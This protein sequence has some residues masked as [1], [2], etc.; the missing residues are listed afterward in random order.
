MLSAHTEGNSPPPVTYNPDEFWLRTLL[1]WY[2]GLVIRPSPTIREI[3]ERRAVCWLGLGTLAVVGSAMSVDDSM[4]LRI[5][6]LES[7]VYLARLDSSELMVKFK[8]DL[9]LFP[10]S[11]RL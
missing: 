5:S 8:S 7:S 11:V 9:S 4:M 1:R 2:I 6:W 3:V 10:C